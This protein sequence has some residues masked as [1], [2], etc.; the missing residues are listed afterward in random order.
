MQI[1]EKGIITSRNIK[2]KNILI[3]ER[4]YAVM[5]I[6][7]QEESIRYQIQDYSAACIFL[8]LNQFLQ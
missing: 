5:C 6:S 1:K 7:I 4:I 3:G 2:N 8:S